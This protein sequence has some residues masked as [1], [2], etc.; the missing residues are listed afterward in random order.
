MPTERLTFQSR[1]GAQL[2][3]RLERPDG[4]IEAYALFAHCFACTKNSLAAV[5]IARG[6]AA[7][8]IATLRFDFTGLGES[9]GE[10]GQHPYSA[11]V[12]D[13]A[14]AAA[15]M[16]AQGMSAQLL[17]GHSL[18]GTAALAAAAQ[19]PDV[20]AVVTIGSPYEASHVTNLFAAELDEIM[21]YGEAPVRLGPATFS[22]SRNFVED[23]SRHSPHE[24][25]QTLGRALLILHAPTDA[26]V[27][28]ENAESIFSVAR[29][30]KS[31]V[32]LDTADHLLTN[33]DDARYAAGVIAA[34]ASR[35]L[36]LAQQGQT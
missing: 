24:R 12:A 26:I 30:P 10:F 14:A 35:Y 15:F 4:G 2:S 29:H 33:G 18:G 9:E 16:E 21:R 32:S 27:G 25:I 28:I 17:I 34:W 7:H 23:L 5:H 19:M 3:A 8:G 20:K 11:D 13:L 22:L 1:S 31:Y 36:G 6:L